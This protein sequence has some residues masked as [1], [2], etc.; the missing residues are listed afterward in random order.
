V[1]VKN[2]TGFTFEDACTYHIPSACRWPPPLC[3]L[4]L[5]MLQL[6]V[7]NSRHIVLASKHPKIIQN[8]RNCFL[9]H[10]ANVRF[11]NFRSWHSGP[12]IFLACQMVWH[13]SKRDPGSRVKTGFL[14]ETNVSA[15]RRSSNIS[16]YQANIDVFLLNYAVT[17]NL[18]EACDRTQKNTQGVWPCRLP[19]DSLPLQQLALST[20][21]ISCL[22][23]QPRW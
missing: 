20:A 23:K 16:E 10:A 12:R 7:V 13:N 11:S 21:L 8:T 19:I 2:K 17:V 1:R 3:R 6:F 5:I 18:N 14:S 4:S 15:N 9:W 22:G